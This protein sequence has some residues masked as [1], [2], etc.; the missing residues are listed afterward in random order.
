MLSQ[1][2]MLGLTCM[3]VEH[4]RDA[5]RGTDERGVFYLGCEAGGVLKCII[6]FSK[7]HDKISATSK[8]EAFRNSK[9][10]E[11]QD[12]PPEVVM[13]ITF[14][15]EPHGGP[16]HAVAASSLQRNLFISCGADCTLRLHNS[17]SAKPMHSFE[18]S[19]SYL[20][21]ASWST[22]RPLVFA[23]G[24][25]KGSVHIYDFVKSSYQPVVS[26][27]MPDASNVYAMAFNPVGGD[28]LAAGEGSGAVRVWKVARGLTMPVP[29]ELEKAN[30]MGADPKAR[31]E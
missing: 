21:S 18:P 1:Q 14:S 20:Y 29:G 8:G 11:A 4:V 5:T 3:G 19:S 2:K 27:D 17:Y 6:Q 30:V 25:G 7:I 9:A 16:V 12:E 26:L 31:A 15:Y 10:A 22:A 28:M 24:D 23:T 13:P